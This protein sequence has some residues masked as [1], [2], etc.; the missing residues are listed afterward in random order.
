MNEENKAIEV[1]GYNKEEL[2]ISLWVRVKSV[3][4]TNLLR[5]HAQLISNTELV[6][7]LK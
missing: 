5:N 6:P 4:P 1:Q 2:T 7:T 3:K